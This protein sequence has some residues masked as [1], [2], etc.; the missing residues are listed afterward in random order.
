MGWYEIG[1]KI[2]VWIV[3][4]LFAID[5]IMHKQALIHNIKMK[6]LNK[7]EEHLPS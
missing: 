4:P 3:L 1:R 2:V 6:M 7:T 5:W